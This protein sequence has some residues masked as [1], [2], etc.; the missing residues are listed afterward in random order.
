M[1]ELDIDGYGKFFILFN[2]YTN[3]YW[4]NIFKNKSLFESLLWLWEDNNEVE[5][6]Q[7]FCLFIFLF[8]FHPSIHVKSICSI[9]FLFI[10]GG[11]LMVVYSSFLV[12]IWPNVVCVFLSVLWSFY[13]SSVCCYSLWNS[14]RYKSLKWKMKIWFWKNMYINMIYV[15]MDSEM[16]IRI[17]I[18]I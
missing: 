5:M 8:V 7:I 4:W 17:I 11:F 12:G 16:D 13:L 10:F 15:R 1:N 9:F 3:F 2:T 14:R 18:D 6:E